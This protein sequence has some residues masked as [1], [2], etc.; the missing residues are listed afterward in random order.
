MPFGV[1]KSSAFPNGSKNLERLRRELGGIAAGNIGTMV[2]SSTAAPHTE[3]HSRA[4]NRS[5]WFQPSAISTAFKSARALFTVSSNSLDGT[6]SATIPAPAW[7]RA[8][9]FSRTIVRIVM[10]VSMFPP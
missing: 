3:R 9:P 4:L 10:H 2:R 5:G 6:E 8:T 1:R 7:T